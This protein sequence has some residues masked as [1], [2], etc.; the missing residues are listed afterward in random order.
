MFPRRFFRKTGPGESLLLSER[1]KR[2]RALLVRTALQE[3]C[4][5]PGSRPRQPQNRARASRA[6]SGTHGICGE[7]RCPAVS[8]TVVY[9]IPAA[10]GIF[11]VSGEILFPQLK[12]SFGITESRSYFQGR[13]LVFDLALRAGWPASAPGSRGERQNAASRIDTD[14]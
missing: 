4:P 8:P 14:H 10:S 3:L 5:H 11:R 2:C 9:R 1:R 7:R 13:T 6:E 12:G